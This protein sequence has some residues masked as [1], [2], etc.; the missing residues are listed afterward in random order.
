MSVVYTQISYRSLLVCKNL[1]VVFD[2][3]F[4]SEKKNKTKKKKTFLPLKS[5]SV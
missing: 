1:F 3:H 2:F 4:F 5:T